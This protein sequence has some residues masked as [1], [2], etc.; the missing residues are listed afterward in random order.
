MDKQQ[1]NRSPNI[2]LSSLHR[3]DSCNIVRRRTSIGGPQ[4][5]WH[6]RC[7]VI[8]SWHISHNMQ[9]W[10]PCQPV[11]FFKLQTVVACQL[12]ADACKSQA[13]RPLVF[14]PPPKHV[15]PGDIG[16]TA[17]VTIC[18]HVY[19]HCDI[20]TN[21]VV[22][23]QVTILCADLAFEA[24]AFS[25][26]PEAIHEMGDGWCSLQ[27]M[28]LRSLAERTRTLNSQVRWHAGF[29]AWPS[30]KS[31]LTHPETWH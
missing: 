26:C 20:D 24:I 3:C 29:T 1:E 19:F 2:D 10:L 16:W 6:W 9:S 28:S 8:P 23:D 11:S 7:F 31:T 17:E 22:G 13:S 18:H 4:C 14:V 12:R 5:D 30:H 15:I 21:K 25:S 27:N